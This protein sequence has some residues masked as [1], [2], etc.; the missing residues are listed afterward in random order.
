MKFKISVKVTLFV[1]L[2]C[3]CA[4]LSAKVVPKMT[5]TVLG[6]TLNHTHSLAHS[7]PCICDV[8]TL[9]TVGTFLKTC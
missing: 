5:N 1:P 2:L 7:P 8:D 3:V 6:G 4:I 9:R